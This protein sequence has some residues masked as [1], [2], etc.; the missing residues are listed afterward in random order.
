MPSPSPPPAPIRTAQQRAALATAQAATNGSDGDENDTARVEAGATSDNA[1]QNGENVGDGQTNTISEGKQKARAV[2]AASGLTAD[3]E[4]AHTTP[5]ERSKSPPPND[6]TTNGLVPSRKRSRSGSRIS[7]PPRTP[8]ADLPTRTRASTEKV[9]IERW[10]NREQFH[11]AA[12]L[13]DDQLRKEV[14]R[15]ITRETDGY[16]R[17][18]QTRQVNPGSIFGNGYAG[19]G[20]G[21]T[22][23]QGQP[24]L[25][26]IVYPIQRKRPGGRRTRELHI[27]R[28]ELATQSEQLDELVPVRLDIEWDKIRLRDTFTWNIHDRVVPPQLFA[29][30][31]VEDFKLPLDQCGLLVQQVCSSLQEQIQDFYPQVFIDEEALDPHL[32]YHAY[33]NDEMRIAI[34]LNIT[35]GQHTLVDQFEWDI[36]NPLNSPED[37]A[38]QMTTDLSLSGEFT[39]AIAHSIREQS[40]LFTRSLYVTGH[41]FDGR[42]IEDPDLK[43]GFLPSPIPSPFRP[44]QAAKDF[45]PYLYELN[46]MDLEKTELSLSREQRRQKRSVNRRGGPTLPDLKDRQRTIRTLVVSSVLPG[47]AESLEDSRIFKRSVTASGRGRR[48]GAGQ[49]DNLDESEDSESEDSSPDSPAIPAYLLSG[50]ARTRGMRGAASAAQAA[51]RANLGR[52]AT[53]DPVALHHHETRTSG[54]RLGGRE[55]REES[56]EESTSYI[57]KLHIP[58][59]RYR[60]FMRELKIRSKADA[61]PSHAS[62]YHYPTSQRSSQSAT[63]GRATPGAGS[64]GPPPTTPGMQQQQLPG[65]QNGVVPHQQPQAGAGGP[66]Q[67]Q[68]Q[69]QQQQPPQIGGVDASGPPGPDNT[70]PPPPT[71]LIS[72]LSA[73]SAAY[74]SDQFEAKMRHSTV[75]TLSNQPVTLPAGA[76]LP[77]DVNPQT[78]NVGK[79]VVD[80]S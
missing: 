14:I 53:P 3:P 40:Q 4:S 25:P 55:Y 18:A 12:M 59:D 46:E 57:V 38:R 29:E 20:N 45:T 61:L 71:W 23:V 48:P 74:P 49:K 43:S 1:R 39:T 41:P 36:N 33:K 68:H 78:E 6:A 30:Q 77:P 50:T 66:Q 56:F 19:Y 63:P 34:K 75:N 58:P 21:H 65:H 76:P 47:A 11:S 13:R 73:L 2:M 10:Q 70:P 51:L 27:L 67:P 60:K 54:R 17:L 44:Y 5:S 79:T 15:G 42:P 64:M 22:N 16:R 28:K 72:A 32:P 7:Q 24:R 62:S 37:F 8:S 26:K 35:I 31:L 52:S 69:Q 80:A 9:L